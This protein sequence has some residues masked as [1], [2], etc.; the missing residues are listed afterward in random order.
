VTFDLVR[1]DAKLESPLLDL[2]TKPIVLTII[3]DVTF[4]GT[5]A[6]GNDVSVVASVTINFA[7]FAG[8]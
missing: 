3:A 7:N 1:Q 4:Y 6:V 5:D 8:A 2:R